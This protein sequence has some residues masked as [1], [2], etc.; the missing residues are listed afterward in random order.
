MREHTLNLAAT[1]SAL[2]CA[3][4]HELIKALYG[5]SLPESVKVVVLCRDSRV[6]FEFKGTRR[7]F[8]LDGRTFDGLVAARRA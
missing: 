8:V 3:P 6:H 4:A 2:N 5:K 7:I 1:L